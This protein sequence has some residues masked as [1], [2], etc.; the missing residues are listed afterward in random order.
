[1]GCNIEFEGIDSKL[2]FKI[3]SGVESGREI[4]IENKGYFDEN[5]KRGNLIAKIKIVV[6]KE[7]SKQ[8]RELYEK[9]Q[10][11]TDFVPRGN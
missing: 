6:P 1:M 5:T 9:L 2:D 3:P 8:E 4:L 7:L 11:I 10:K